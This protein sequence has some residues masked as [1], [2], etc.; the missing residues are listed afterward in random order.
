MRI[1]KRLV[2]NWMLLSFFPA[3]TMCGCSIIGLTI[4]MSSDARRP[5]EMTIP[6][7]KADSLRANDAIEV[8][9]KDGAAMT[10]NNFSVEPLPF[11]EYTK[12]YAEAQTRLA[13]EVTLPDL[14]D[15]LT[16][17]FA[18]FIPQSSDIMTTGQL[19]EFEVGFVRFTTNEEGKASMRTRSLS[20]LLRLSD[21]KGKTF[22]GEAIRNLINDGKIPVRTGLILAAR[23]EQ[24]MLAIN[25]IE[26]IRQSAAPKT[27]A[28]A[29]FV[30]GAI[31]DAM[32]VVAVSSMSFGGL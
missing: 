14:G 13:A 27:G 6:G 10:S 5:K 9:L 23:G 18:S 15:T 22:T 25:Q 31:L 7:L 21:Q 2:R 4:G 17:S 24:R 20:E 16:L 3:V 11:Y 30:L 19:S 29:G 28:L 26:Q 12:L 1:M 32:A 8:L